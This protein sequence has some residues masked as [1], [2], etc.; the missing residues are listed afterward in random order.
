MSVHSSPSPSSFNTRVEDSEPGVG[1]SRTPAH[2]LQEEELIGDSLDTKSNEVHQE[3]Q[4][5]H[6][7]YLVVFQPNDPENPK[8]RG[9]GWGTSRRHNYKS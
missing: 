1:L 2:A 4:P 8:V 6:V 7:P 5:S 3:K 9:Y